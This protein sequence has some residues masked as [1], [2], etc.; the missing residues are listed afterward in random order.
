MLPVNWEIDKPVTLQGGYNGN[1]SSRPGY[2]TLDGVV[3]VGGGS[4]GVEVDRV[5]VK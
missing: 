4:I 5:I 3:T 1:F 2:T